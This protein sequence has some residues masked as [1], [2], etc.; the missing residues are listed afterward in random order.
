MPPRRPGKRWVNVAIPE[1]DYIRW[2]QLALFEGWT[3]TEFLIR[4]VKRML[5]SN[6]HRFDYP[7]EYFLPAT[8]KAGQDRPR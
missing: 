5:K 7:P 6:H 8:K 1:M 2:R 3:M 4:A